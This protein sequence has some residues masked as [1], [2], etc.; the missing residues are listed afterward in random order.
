MN[1]EE[2]SEGRKRSQLIRAGAGARVGVEEQLSADTT[3]LYV[4][5]RIEPGPHACQPQTRSPESSASVHAPPAASLLWPDTCWVPVCCRDGEVGARGWEA[6]PGSPCPQS[7]GCSGKTFGSTLGHLPANS[8]S[9]GAGGQVVGVGGWLWE[10]SEAAVS[11]SLQTEEQPAWQM[12]TGSLPGASERTAQK[13]GPRWTEPRSPG[14]DPVTDAAR[15][16]L[17]TLLQPWTPCAPVPTWIHSQ[18]LPGSSCSPELLLSQRPQTS[19]HVTAPKDVTLY[20][21][22]MAAV[23]NI[24]YWGPKKRKELSAN[25]VAATPRWLLHPKLMVS[26]SGRSQ[27]SHHQGSRQSTVLLG[28]EDPFS[29]ASSLPRHTHG[30]LQRGLRQVT[31][32]QPDKQSEAPGRLSAPA[33]NST[34][35]RAAT[36]PR[37]PLLS[38]PSTP[39][40]GKPAL[41]QTWSLRSE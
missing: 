8:P 6:N 39:R 40:Q 38:R 4:V 15:T 18:G 29:L 9:F 7:S 5:L 32:P 21:L 1:F 3:S 30:A 14:C 31:S 2:P 33:P 26:G 10:G 41:F 28:E 19:L 36:S 34:L 35:V 17:E 27:C 37:D 23:T 24:T 20:E 12:G 16:P 25:Q 13:P 22:P 11:R